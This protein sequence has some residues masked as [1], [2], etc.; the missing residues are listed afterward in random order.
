MM[1]ETS[2]T[3]VVNIFGESKRLLKE[4]GVMMHMDNPRLK[5]LPPL[6]SFLAEWE[7]YNNNERFGGTYRE[8][9]VVAEAVKAGFSA[10]KSRMD[11]VDTY[12]PGKVMNYGTKG[13]Q[14]PACIAEK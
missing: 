6:E 10:E 1:H 14:F 9:D 4:G 12:M 11:M 2:T 8:M 13:I 5:G 3:A 7:V